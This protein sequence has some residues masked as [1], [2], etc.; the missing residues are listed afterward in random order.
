MLLVQVIS[1]GLQ[2]LSRI[3]LSQGIFAFALMTYR[4]AVAALVMMPFAIYFERGILKKL[5]LIAFF[6]VFMVALVGITMAMGLFYYGLKETTATYAT[7]FTNIVPIL[8]F[9]FSTILRYYVKLFNVFPYKYTATFLI[10]LVASIQD[11]VIGLCMD[12]KPKS[13][14]LGWNLQLIT[15]LYSGILATAGS[16][17]LISWAVT[18]KGPTYPSMFNP[19]ALIFVTIT[20][21]LF[22]GEAITVQRCSLIGMSLIIVGLY[23]FL[24]GKHK[25][26][27]GGARIPVKESG[28]AGG[29]APSV[30]PES[31]RSQSSAVVVPT[32]SS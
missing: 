1:T 5:T 10:C 28:G 18:Q 8:T 20:E 2:L 17:T 21:A 24:W 14:Q 16:F 26:M 13:W 4:H 32:A 23:L 29:D 6:W 19:L 15:I 27:K 30:E 22:L 31:V 11:V 7:N 12:R 9:L 25:D 3:V